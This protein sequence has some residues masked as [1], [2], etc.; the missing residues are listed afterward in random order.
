MERFEPVDRNRGLWVVG[1]AILH[2]GTCL[3]TRRGPQDRLAGKWE[4]PGGKLEP[5]ETAV[6]ALQREIKE[7][8]DLDI[9]VGEWLARGRT[10]LDGDREIYLDVFVCRWLDGTLTLR[11]HDD[12]K[13]CG[14][15]AL[16][17]L[18][19]AAA[20]VPIWPVVAERLR[21]RS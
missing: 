12:F 8:L 19:W 14:P 21:N 10:P 9:A 2:Q 13:W 11:D 3:A 15:D 7:E 16:A 20:D 4:F 5:G 1:A 17:R 6:A 18:D